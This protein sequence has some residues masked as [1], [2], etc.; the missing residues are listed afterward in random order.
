MTYYDEIDHQLNQ[1][2][3]VADQPEPPVEKGAIITAKEIIRQLR[4]TRFAPPQITWQG[5]DS[6]VMIW[7]FNSMTWAVTITE[8]DVGYVVRR[9]RKQIRIRD[10]IAIED[11]KM[12]DV[13]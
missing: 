8:G 12:L 3:S 9:D 11:F 4:N 10:S 2:E 13:K 6:I 1:L 5:G 7:A